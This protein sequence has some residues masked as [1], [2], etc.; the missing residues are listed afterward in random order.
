M[1]KWKMKWAG[2][3]YGVEGFL[4]TEMKGSQE[5]PMRLEDIAGD[6]KYLINIAL[7]MDRKILVD[8]WHEE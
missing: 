6:E 7:L 5:Y 2:D 8:C 1:N 3:K 4:F